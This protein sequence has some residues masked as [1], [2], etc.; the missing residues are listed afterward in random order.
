MGSQQL[1]VSP[2]ELQVQLCLWCGKLTNPNEFFWFTDCRMRCEFARKQHL[3]ALRQGIATQRKELKCAKYDGTNAED[4][5]I[6]LCFTR[7]GSLI[8]YGVQVD[9]KL[10]YFGTSLLVRAT[11]IFKQIVCASDCASSMLH[12]F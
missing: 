5:E 12:I 11:E 6:G 4:P 1:C 7:E 2:S 9:D 3:E 10:L 8:L